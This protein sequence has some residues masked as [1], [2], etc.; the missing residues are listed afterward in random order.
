MKTN[1]FYMPT[2]SKQQR[3]PDE[4]HVYP[5]TVVSVSKQYKNRIKRICL[6]QSG[7]H[8]RLAEFNLFLFC[9]NI[10]EKCSF[11]I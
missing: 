3:S 10:A 4:Q 2:A 5:W 8:Y 7:H 11:G 6:V 9:H 1:K